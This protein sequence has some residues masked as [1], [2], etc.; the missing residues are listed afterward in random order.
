[1][2]REDYLLDENNDFATAN[3]DFV[4]GASDDQHV[5][6]LL[7]L[8]KGE[9]K[10]NP[11]VG[12]GL[13]KFLKQQN[14]SLNQIKREIK[15]GLKTDGYTVTDLSISEDGSFELDYKLEE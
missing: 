13:N 10:E 9:L 14:T 15:V 5:E 6:M 12:I 3:G 11:T 7:E 2:A 8:N 1:M 4:T